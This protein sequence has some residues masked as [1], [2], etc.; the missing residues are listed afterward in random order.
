M[1]K[2]WPYF[3]SWRGHESVGCG[4]SEA[5][6]LSLLSSTSNQGTTFVLWSTINYQSEWMP[7]M[8]EWSPYWGE[9]NTQP[10]THTIGTKLQ[11]CWRA[12]LKALSLV[13]EVLSKFLKKLN[14][15]KQEH[16][17]PQKKNLL[18]SEITCGMGLRYNLIG[19]CLYVPI[20]WNKVT[21]DHSQPSL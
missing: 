13:T 3:Q 5:S 21:N 4:V 6:L 15:Q 14:K 16:P 8:S 10:H 11:S 12:R 19:S 9:L 7:Q 20:R 18:R 17:P 1:W 2:L